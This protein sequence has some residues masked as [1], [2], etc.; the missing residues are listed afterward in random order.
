MGYRLPPETARMVLD[1]YPGAEAVVKLYLPLG[2]VL[3]MQR[4][5][6]A[7]NPDDVVA[8]MRWFGDI[9]LLSWNLETVNGEPV[10]ATGDTMLGLPTELALAMVNAWMVHVS[11]L[12][13]PLA[14]PSPDGRPSA[15]VSVKMESS[16]VSQ[17]S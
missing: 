11:G 1:D 4:D 14:A 5:L 3:R 2:D 7:S 9:I 15:A 12:P 6:A 10:P 8:A 17:S 13:A 16:L